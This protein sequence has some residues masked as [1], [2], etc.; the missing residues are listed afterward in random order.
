MAISCNAPLLES[1]VT[2]ILFRASFTPYLFSK[3]SLKT[4]NAIA[5]SVVVP[6]FEITLTD[7]SLSPINDAM[8]G[9]VSNFG[10][11]CKPDGTYLCNIKTKIF[12]SYKLT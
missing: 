2:Y 11:E 8:L 3:N 7:K 12:H 4:L 5:G 6:D 10:W 1:V 9:T